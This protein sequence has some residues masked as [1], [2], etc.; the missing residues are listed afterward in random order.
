MRFHLSSKF[1]DRLSEKTAAF[2]LLRVGHWLQKKSTNKWSE[3]VV[4]VSERG[5][6]QVPARIVSA[7]PEPFKRKSMES[8][9]GKDF[10]DD[11]PR[12][13]EDAPRQNRNLVPVPDWAKEIQTFLANQLSV[14]TQRA[15]ET[16]LKQFFRFL[17]GKIS[18]FRLDQLAPEHVILFRKHL[19]EGRI[20]G[21]P[22]EKS[23]I[24]RKL[25]VIKSF[26]NWLKLNRHIIENPASLVKGYPQSQE[27]SLKG[28]SDLEARE[29]LEKPNRNSRSGSLHWAVL[30]T[31]LY[32]GVRKGELIGLKIG[33]LSEE[34]G[35]KVMKVRGKGHRI[36]ILPM[37]LPVQ[38]AI[39][40]YLDICRR[41][42][43]ETEA[44]LFTPT[45]NP[46]TKTMIKP[47]NPNAISYIVI[48]YARKAGV[49]KQISPHSCR[50]TCISNALD[51]RA[52]QRSVQNLAGWST[53]LMIQR[54]DKRREDLKNSAAF[55]VDYG[56]EP[57]KP[58]TA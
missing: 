44:P 12:Q 17:E 4:K 23:T 6:V 51:R 37:T 57:A 34:R 28:L 10:P 18:L 38:L 2:L 53:P 7:A 36:R 48:R 27:S 19:E 22:M 56:E 55:L 1:W 26:L 29:M 52:T 8:L 14:H 35:T 58:A 5:G 9:A 40:N 49:L 42:M 13:F 30:N 11:T 3:I 47:L 43:T 46:R 33:D 31:L 15:Y 41:D 24:N 25:A 45:K 39:Q 54:Y 16:D 21:K 32:L 50:A 20:G